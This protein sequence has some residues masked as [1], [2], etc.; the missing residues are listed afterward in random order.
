MPRG[1][2]ETIFPR[3][4]SLDTIRFL[5]NKYVFSDNENLTPIRFDYKE[6]FLLMR[7][8][9]IDLNFIYDHYPSEFIAHAEDF[10]SQVAN[11]DYLNLF[12][13]T[14]KY[15]VDFDIT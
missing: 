4:L 14:L 9:R 1:N 10:V 7:K 5:L 3:I 13:S 2:L 8:H 6:S 15:F 11:E 12:L